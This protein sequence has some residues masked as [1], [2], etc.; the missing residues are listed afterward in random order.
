MGVTLKKPTQMEIF[1]KNTA[2][3]LT[4]LASLALAFSPMLANN[5]FAQ[6]ETG[7]ASAAALNRS[8]LK[9]LK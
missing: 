3:L 9:P 1:M 8:K 4:S 5:A 6:V 7:G 2:R